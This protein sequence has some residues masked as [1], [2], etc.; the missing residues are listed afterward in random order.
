[1]SKR[2]D[3]GIVLT[4]RLGVSITR[5]GRTMSPSSPAWSC[6]SGSTLGLDRRGGLARRNAGASRR[7]PVEG[8]VLADLARGLALV[9]VGYGRAAEP[10]G[11]VRA[12]GLDAPRRAAVDVAGVPAAAGGLPAGRIKTAAKHPMLLA[13]KVV[14]HGAPVGQR[15]RCRRAALRRLSRL[16][17]GRP[18]S[19]KRRVQRP[20]WGAGGSR[21]TTR[22]PSSPAWRS[23]PSSS[24][25]ATPG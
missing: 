3:R 4:L 5:A 13:V 7:G 11:A 2:L 12:A 20:P 21:S 6:S 23:T 19:L 8:P 10:G 25:A 1:M 18:I 22:S 16:G 17:G 9:I 24:S 15:Q 14:G